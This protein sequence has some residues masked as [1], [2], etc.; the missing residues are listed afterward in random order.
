MGTESDRNIL[1]IMDLKFF[2]NFGNKVISRAAIP[3]KSHEVTAVIQE[4]QVRQILGGS[5]PSCV[6]SLSA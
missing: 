3:S 1:S 4:A 2:E 5:Q 6:A